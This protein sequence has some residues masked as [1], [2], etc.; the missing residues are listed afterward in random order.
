MIDTLFPCASR[1]IARPVARWLLMFA[2][3][4]GFGCASMRVTN[5]RSTAT[6]Q[7]LQ[8]Q[9]VSQAI[10]QLSADVMRD[11]RVFVDATYLTGSKETAPEYSYLL[12][13]LRS[14]LLTTGV[15]LTDNRAD[16]QIILE[17]RSG[18]VGV[19]RA[20][21]LLG[22]PPITFSA[23]SEGNGAA[24]PEL[25]IIKTTSQAGYASVAF[26]AYW[27]DTGE[28]VASS[29]PFT[30]RTLRQDY[31]ILGTGP[32]TVGDIPTVGK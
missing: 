23:D 22:I 26:V 10:G 24:T 32:R 20:E 3:A 5:S 7:Y 29:G 27:A 6:E 28:I 17:V 18:A 14:R 2:A 12:G 9:A 13:E 21:F 31:W 15:R 11:R 19:D 25:A 16:A 8:S 4:G 1:P 30:G